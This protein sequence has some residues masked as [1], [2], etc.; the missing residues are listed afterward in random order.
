MLDLAETF[1]TKSIEDKVD[2]INDM[3]GWKSAFYI[4]LW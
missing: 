2:E 1:A 4:I 3:S